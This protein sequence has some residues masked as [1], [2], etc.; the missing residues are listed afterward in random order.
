MLAI[1]KYIHATL[2]LRNKHASVTKF[3]NKK[4]EPSHIFSIGGGDSLTL[5]VVLLPFYPI[6]QEKIPKATEGN[7]PCASTC[8]HAPSIHMTSIVVRV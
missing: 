8:S 2:L 7:L 4:D 1:Y 3:N 5:Y 6:S